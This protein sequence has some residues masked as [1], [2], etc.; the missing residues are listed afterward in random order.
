MGLTRKVK[1]FLNVPKKTDSDPCQLVNAHVQAR[2]TGKPSL[3]AYLGLIC[4]YSETDLTREQKMGSENVIR[5]S[6]A[7]R[8]GEERRG[9]KIAF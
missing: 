4:I 9:E 2:Q 6:E 8:R 3:P 5:T 1:S 7:R